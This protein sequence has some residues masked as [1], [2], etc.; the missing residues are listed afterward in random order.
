M[1]DFP[2][3]KTGVVVV[4]WNAQATVADCVRSFLQEGIAPSA[5]VVVDN[6]STD[7]SIALLADS[8][9]QVR[10]LAN[11]VN[12]Y[13]RAVNM[14]VAALQ[15]VFII[16][17]N[18]DLV[19]KPGCLASVL[20]LFEDERVAAVGCRLSDGAGNDVTRFSHTSVFRAV[21]LLCAPDSLRGV[22][23][24]R[25]QRC[26]QADAP[27]SVKYIEGSFMAVRRTA[28]EELNG[29]D[30]RFIFFHED[31]DF[32]L[33]LTQAGWQALHHPKAEAVHYCGQSFR[34]APFFRNVQFYR[35]TLLF[36]QQHYPLRYPFLRMGVFVVL[37]VMT[38]AAALFGA[39]GM[40]IPQR[41]E[42]TRSL[43]RELRR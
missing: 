34:Q 7:G 38:A 23:R 9:P 39:C 36:F 42:Q 27:F 35:S 37:A 12:S 24:R 5:I 6:G 14:G 11:P 15:S 17:A 3:T 20:A 43:R 1:A 33:R 4:N 31:S 21:G 16:I 19:L 22:L 26:V 30:E 28:F 32:I 8:F 2:I 41:L 18:P 25:E 29:F 40:R 10:I 13:S